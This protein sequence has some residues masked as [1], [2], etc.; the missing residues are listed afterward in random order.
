MVANLHKKSKQTISVEPTTRQSKLAFIQLVHRRR[1]PL[2]SF[3]ISIHF[4]S[5]LFSLSYLFFL[6]LLSYLDIFPAPPLVSFSVFSSFY[7]NGVYSLQSTFPY[8]V[9]FS[10]K[11]I[12]T[13][14]RLLII[15][16]LEVKNLRLSSRLCRLPSVWPQTSPTPCTL[17]FFHAK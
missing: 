13:I 1:H 17:M 4:L 6:L 7:Y 12:H 15:H 5:C 2:V 9:L 8:I 10:K 3:F 14:L 11:I 16:I